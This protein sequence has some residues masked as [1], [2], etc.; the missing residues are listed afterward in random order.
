MHNACGSIRAK[1]DRPARLVRPTDAN[2]R[3]EKFLF[4][5]D[6]FAQFVPRGWRCPLLALSGHEPVLRTCPLSGVKRTS[7]FAG[8]RFHGRYWRQSVHALLHCIRPLMTQSGHRGGHNTPFKQIIPT[9]TISALA[10][11][12]AARFIIVLI[13]AVF[14]PF[15]DPLTRSLNSCG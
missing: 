4:K 6:H 13:G 14:V 8:V 12:K 2:E 5:I 3:E 7:N 15:S 11:A 9:G 1:R 10:G